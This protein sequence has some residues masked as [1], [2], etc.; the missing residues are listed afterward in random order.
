MR[1]ALP[2]LPGCSAA[3]AAWTDC[4]GETIARAAWPSRLSRDG[5]LHVATVSSTW[6]FELGRL[7]GQITD[8]LRAAIGAD[9]VTTLRFAPGPVPGPGHDVEESALAAPEITLRSRLEGTRLAAGVGDP[10]LR[11]LIARAAAASLE[12]ARSDRGFC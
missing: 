12:R 3:A 11:D 7:A 1:Q 6:A 10:E 2:G 9:A 8:R 4:V 5:T